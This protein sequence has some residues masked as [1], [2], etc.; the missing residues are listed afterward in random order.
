MTHCRLSCAMSRSA[1]IE[2]S[3][4]LTTATSSTV[5]NWTAQSTA[6]AHHLRSI[7]VMRRGYERPPRMPV[8]AAVLRGVVNRLLTAR[9]NPDARLKP[10]IRRGYLP[11]GGRQGCELVAHS[12]ELR[13]GEVEVVERM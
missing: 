9:G 1:W 3:A 7:D 2:G 10:G 11:S 12:H 5:M 8:R 6:R 4:T 13:E